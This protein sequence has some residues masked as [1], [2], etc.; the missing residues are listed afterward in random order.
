MKKYFIISALI[1]LYLTGIQAIA[2]ED[3]FLWLEEVQGEKALE[4]VKAQNKESVAE[5][6]SAPGFKD[7]YNKMLEILNSKERIP[8]PQKVDNYI[9]N[10]WQDATHKRGI[11]RRTTLAEYRKDNPKWETVFDLDELAK[12]EKE[13]WVWKGITRL[14]PDYN[15]GLMMLSRGGADATVV[16]EF[17]IETK[18]FVKDGFE[19]P[20][21]KSTVMWRD[22][23]H[24]YVGTDF[25][26]G[27]L[28][29]SGYPLVVKLWKRGTPLKDAE[30]IFTA[31]KSSVRGYGMRAFSES[32]HLDLLMDFVSFFEIEY[33][34]LQD[35]KP[36]RLNIP[37]DV[38]P[39]SYFNGEYIMR[40][41]SDWKV[42]DKTFK[43]GSIIIGDLK[44]VLAGKMEFKTLIEPSERVSISGVDTTKNLVLVSV[45]DNVVSKLYQFTR[46]KNGKWHKKQV[47]T[48]DN[49]SLNVFNASEKNDDYFINYQNMLTPVSYYLVSGKDA[50]PQLIKSQS[51]F[52]NSKPYKVQQ[53]NATSKDGTKVPYFIIMRKDA[54]MNGKNPTLLYA[55]GGFLISM[56]PNYSATRGRL[57]LEKGGV[58]VLANI[59]GGGEFGPKWH[60][61]A[62]LKNRHKAFE[63]FIAVGEDL[64][65][66]KVTSTE[67]LAIQGGSNGGL[68]VGAVFLMRPDLFKAVVCQVPLLDMKRYHKLLAG[69]SWMSEYG[70]PDKPDMWEYIKTYSP[71][72]N[73]E[74]GKKYPKVFFT[75]STRDD[76]VHPGHARKMVAKMKQMGYP[77]YYY[78]NTEGGHAGAANNEQRAFMSALAYT[79]LYMQ[80]MGS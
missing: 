23:D 72:Q 80:L 25:G 76:R 7:T 52:F 70:D 48:P 79:Y 33:Y 46:D 15:R 66:R 75:T 56:R 28:S 54:K 47:P 11:F 20:E 73:V 71:Y 49:G 64:I 18:S 74:K 44:K 17:D 45:L 62:L 32:G 27:T 2:Q 24:V 43:Q 3:P 55:Y 78:E 59:R 29:T 34:V 40:L 16:R 12:K 61:A 8:F 22:I 5:L 26:E 58:F 77:V 35:G 41:D 10:Y 38:R 57:W 60:Q 31:K 50:K 65:K 1:L 4:W 68:L 14:Y 19:L 9:Y 69:A 37:K 39:M 42:G 13:N 63:D 6:E 30:T 53:F 21:A 67:K 51:H 36:V